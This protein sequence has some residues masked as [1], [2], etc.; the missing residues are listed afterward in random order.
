MDNL[1]HTAIGLF[2]SRAGLNRWTPL[3][4]PILILAANAPDIDAIAIAGGSLNYLNFHRHVTHSLLAMPVLA[5]LSVALVRLIS[6]KPVD[7]KGAFFGALIAVGSHLALDWTN[8]YGIRLLLPFSGEWLRADISSIVDLWIWAVLLLSAAA[9]FLSRLVGGEIGVSQRGR[10]YGRGW[11]IFA[12]LFV[13][14]YDGARGYLH[15]RAVA[16][17]DARLYEGGAPLRVFASPSPGNPFTWRGVVETAEGYSVH[18]L[19]LRQE[20]DPGAGMVYHKPEAGPFLD[21][22]RRTAT[23]RDFLR[24]SQFPLLRVTPIAEPEGAR[25]VEAIDMR[26]ASPAR[27]GFMAT[28]TIDANQRV[29]GTSFEWGAVRP[30]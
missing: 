6:R 29:I 20:F 8:I 5:L 16:T 28:A 30:R 1:T 21:A 12:L 19:N 7:W 3:A 4:T 13:L 18:E 27:P 24:F 15:A 26:F 9:P 22:A 14:L 10:P 2:L 25:Q 23:F 11:A 17:L